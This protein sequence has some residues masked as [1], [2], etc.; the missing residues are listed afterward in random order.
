MAVF[1]T[2]R[3]TIS[4]IEKIINNATSGIV[5]ISPFVK[6]PSSLFQNL[7]AADQRGMKITLVY[8]KKTLELN[9][10]EQLNQLKNAKLYF[11][12]NL[13][14]KCYFNEKSMVITSLNLYDFSEQN[15]RE[16]GVLITRQND[17]GAFTE[18]IREAKMI[19]SLANRSDNNVQVKE[20]PKK[21]VKQ[22]LSVE[23]QKPKSIL[24][25]DLSDIFPS[26][27]GRVHGYCIGCKTKIEYD[28]YKPYCPECYK[29]WVKN[30][31]QKANYCLSCGRSSTTSIHKPFC[32]SC[33]DKSSK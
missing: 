22:Q 5:L 13:H 12:D 17:E 33:F 19:V 9:S 23:K 1:L 28:E 21:Q 31:G 26:F 24:F 32:R 16:M 25:R 4:E 29:T 15:N 20:Q 8:G 6:I 7:R 3:G 11:L 27:F 2:T 18:A 14:A 10:T 30:K